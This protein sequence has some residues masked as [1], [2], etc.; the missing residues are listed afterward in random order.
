MI[1]RPESRR[2]GDEIESRVSADGAEAAMRCV[3]AFNDAFNRHDVD[4]MMA[5]M[6]DDCVFENTAPA[7]DGTRYEGR[8]AVA[9]FWREFFEQSPQAHIDVEDIVGAGERCV[10]LW[11]YE[12]WD[13]AGHPGHVRG[14]DV[15]RV[16]DGVIAEKLSYV[17]G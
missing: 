12:W 8:E 1:H 7:P 11:R 6:T 13:A 17:K 3:L 9:A 10:M 4:G 14:V 5:L 16:R 15:Y 2:A